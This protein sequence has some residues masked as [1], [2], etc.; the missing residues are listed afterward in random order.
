MKRCDV[1]IACGPKRRPPNTVQATCATHGAVGPP[2]AGAPDDAFE[3]AMKDPSQP[4]HQPAPHRKALRMSDTEPTY[5]NGLPTPARKITGTVR[6]W[7][8]GDPPQAWWRPLVGQR[9]E[10]V[11]V[12]LDGVNH[13]GGIATLYDG[14]GSGWRKVTEGHG[15]PRWPHADVPLVD[16][17]ARS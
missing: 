9:V 1:T 4:P 13:G 10:A 11:E 5:W 14:D 17:E 12:V 16:I 3:S 8:P 6:E 2:R 15:G 7:E